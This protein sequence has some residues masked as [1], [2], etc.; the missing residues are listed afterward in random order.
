MEGKPITAFLVTA[1]I[2]WAVYLWRQ[3]R[4]GVSAIPAARVPWA[5]S[6]GKVLR[7]MPVAKIVPPAPAWPPTEPWSQAPNPGGI[8]ATPTIVAPAPE[9]PF[10][11]APTPDEILGGY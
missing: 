9:P 1:L 11:G 8:L 10:G 5:I 4:L 7:P 2:L 6:P 3:N